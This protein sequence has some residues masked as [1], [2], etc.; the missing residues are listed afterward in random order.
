MAGLERGGVVRRSGAPRERPA[1]H[2]LSVVIP[3]YNEAG[4]VESI[5]RYVLAVVETFVD[6]FEIVLVND[7]SHDGS[8]LILDRLAAEDSRIRVYHHPF[9]IGY[10]G[11]HKTGFRNATKTW[12]V[13]VP[14][15]H[16]FDARDLERFLEARKSAD[17]IG[18]YRIDRKDTLRRR[19]ISWLYNAYMRRFYGVPLRDL[20]WIK[21]FRRRIFDELEIESRGFAVDAEIVVKAQA[22]GYRIAEIPVVHHPRTWGNP[23]GVSLKN[24]YKTARELLRI[25]RGKN[26]EGATRRVETAD[27]ESD[28]QVGDDTASSRESAGVAGDSRG[29]VSG[30]G[31]TSPPNRS[32]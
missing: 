32:S 10:G 15:D 17:I 19:V 12:M 27:G 24:L 8:G 25:K 22:K 18:S 14:A 3:V 4:N 26:I 2:S 6:D 7:G 31:R 23:T 11:A 20:N 9:N 29:S 1:E 5:V 16:Q 13:V 21:L 30:P 28:R